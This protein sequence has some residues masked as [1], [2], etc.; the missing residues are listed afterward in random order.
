MTTP[1]DLRRRIAFDARAV[2]DDGMG[3]VE[4]DWVEQFV[5]WAAVRPRLGGET[6][7]AARLAGRQPMLITVRQSTQAKL[8]TTDWRARD[9]L[10]APSA[11]SA[12]EGALYNIRAIAPPNDSRAWLELLCEAGVAT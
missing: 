4:G 11:K 8:I 12:A 6:V 3:N 2:T 7:T 10:K 5:V 1:G 9:P